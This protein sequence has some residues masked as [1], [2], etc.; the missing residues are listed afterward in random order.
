M[1]GDLVAMLLDQVA[2]AEEDLRALADR[3]GAP[4]GESGLRGRD[5]RIDLLDRGEVDA[6]RQAPGRGV[7]DG[8]AAAGR[9]LDEGSADPVVDALRCCCVSGR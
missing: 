8:A 3:G 2:D 1:R 9:A 5:G 6:A 4:A 7:V